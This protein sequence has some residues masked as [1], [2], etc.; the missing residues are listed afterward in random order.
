M[1]NSTL[2]VNSKNINVTSFREELSSS[3]IV[4]Y[5]DDKNKMFKRA[6]SRYWYKQK[7]LDSDKKKMSSQWQSEQ[8]HVKL[9]STGIKENNTSE[10]ERDIHR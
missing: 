10:V 9:Q 5:E 1:T 4:M 7:R 2:T 6:F 3:S 8:S